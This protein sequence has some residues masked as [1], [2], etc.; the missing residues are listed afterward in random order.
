M[1][2]AKQKLVCQ[3]YVQGYPLGECAKR[4]GYTANTDA[5]A[6]K[7]IQ[8]VD[9]IE[10]MQTISRIRVDRASDIKEFILRKLVAKAMFSPRDIIDVH[11]LSSVDDE[12]NTNYKSQ[13]VFKKN[14]CEFTDDELSGLTA[15][16][17]QG[18]NAFIKF[19][20]LTPLLQLGKMVGVL[21]GAG[22][23]EDL[24]AIFQEAVYHTEDSS[25]PELELEGVKEAE[26]E[27]E[28][29]SVVNAIGVYS[30]DSI[31]RNAL[32]GGVS[33]DSE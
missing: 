25:L 26:V 7:I 29:D 21:D 15:I 5:M 30:P 3:N 16:G 1:L 28:D 8:S 2:S 19:D 12:G 11:T 22:D 17:V 33:S 10:Y 14:L 9:G 18:G 27:V 4:A 20:S 23:V 24:N 31:Y 32:V 6:K 13:M